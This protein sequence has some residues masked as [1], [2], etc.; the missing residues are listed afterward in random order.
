MKLARTDK[1]INYLKPIVA[2]ADIEGKF[3]LLPQ[4]DDCYKVIGYNWFNVGDW[5]Y[6]SC[7]FF[8]TV[9]KAVQEYEDFGYE[10]YNVD[11]ELNKL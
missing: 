6:N 1:N 3:I 8:E 10:M 9:E 5:S 7:A 4:I 11:I 2:D